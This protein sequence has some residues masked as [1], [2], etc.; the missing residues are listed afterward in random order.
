MDLDLREER[1][2]GGGGGGGSMFCSGSFFSLLAPFYMNLSINIH[3][4]AVHQ[5]WPPP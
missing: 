2:G 3:V 4:P 1:E 5:H